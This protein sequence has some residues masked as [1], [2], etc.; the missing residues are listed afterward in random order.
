MVA[1]RA[2][3]EANDPKLHQACL[4]RMSGAIFNLEQLA[5]TG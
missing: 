3:E 1:V 5:N 2:P 4:P